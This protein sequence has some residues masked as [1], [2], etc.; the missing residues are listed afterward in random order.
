MHTSVKIIDWSPGTAQQ[1]RPALRLVSQTVTVGELIAQRVTAECC[2]LNEL[3]EL[4]ASEREKQLAAWL[5]VPN[6]N[7]QA[8]NGSGRL[9]G[10][11][12]PIKS[13][14]DPKV[15]I[16]A[17]YWEINGLSRRPCI[18]LDS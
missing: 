5:V 7:E 18:R 6:R 8:L 16:E 15:Q 10:P 12:V 2:A 1:S 9:F 4:S 14:I 13:N 3:E 11:G 17:G